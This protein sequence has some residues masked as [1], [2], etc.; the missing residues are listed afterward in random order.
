MRRRDQE[1]GKGWNREREKREEKQCFLANEGVCMC[2]R[3]SGERK[4]RISSAPPRMSFLLTAITTPF[5]SKLVVLMGFFA[6]IFAPALLRPLFSL[7]LISS[8]LDLF[9]NKRLETVPIIIKAPNGY[10]CTPTAPGTGA[11]TIPAVSV[12]TRAKILC[13]LGLMRHVTMNR[14]HAEDDFRFKHCAPPK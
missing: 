11:T 4:S 3:D 8:T 13:H 10:Y 14:S 2:I 5:R 1:E 12:K 7:W 6:C 9:S